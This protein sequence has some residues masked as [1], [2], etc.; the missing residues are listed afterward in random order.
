MIL[1]F[2]A[3]GF[4]GTYLVDAF[5]KSRM[6]VI[7]SDVCESS[8]TYYEK[9]G[10]PFVRVDVT[11]RGDFKKIDQ[12]GIKAIICLAAMQP[13]NVSAAEYD[14]VE[15]IRVNTIGTL[16]ILAFAK[17]V[18]A[19]KTIFAYSH[20]NTE[21]LW[22][23]GRPIREEDGRHLKYDG[24]ARPRIASSITG[25][26]TACDPLSFVCPRSMAMAPI[27]KFSRTGNT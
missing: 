1:V 24:E 12:A 16:N 26:S 14:P 2:G 8:R 9:R 13:A 25:A 4:I 27:P 20:R 11:E 18:A 7:A 17:T 3:G 5:V 10:I 22:A 23:K 6:A 19:E 21:G 15:Y